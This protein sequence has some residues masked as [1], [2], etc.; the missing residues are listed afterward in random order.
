MLRSDI[1]TIQ[2]HEKGLRF[3]VTQC[4]CGATHDGFNWFGLAFVRRYDLGGESWETRSCKCGRDVVRALEST[5][6]RAA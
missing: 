4:E 2:A 6:P 3:G 1:V 5:P